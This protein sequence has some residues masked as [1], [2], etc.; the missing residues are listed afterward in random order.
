MPS[1]FLVAALT[2]ALGLTHSGLGLA[3]GDP[4]ARSGSKRAAAPASSEDILA[5]TVF[6]ALVG[7][8]ALQRGDPKLGSDA[9]ADLAVRTRD[10]KVIARATEIAGFARQYDRALELSK[11]WLEIE[12]DSAKARQTQ[13]SLLV[14]ANRLDDLAPQLAALLEQDKP[15]IGSNL[16]HLNRMLGKITD[17]KAVQ[18]L[19][20]KVAA[21]YDLL[22]EAHF[23]MAQAAANAGDNLRAL[24]ETEKSLQLRPAW[25]MAAIARAQLQ[26]RQSPKTAIDSLD[27]FV[28]RN[29]NANDARLT[30]ARLL[31]S[32]K[33]Y[34]ESR[35]HFDRLI[36]ANPD[37]P[38]VIYP[39]AM[40]AL[41]QGDTT[42]GRSQLE[43]L[44]QTDFPD[45]NTIH[46]FLGQLDQEQKKP[47]AA[48]AHYRQVAGGEQYVPARSR[49]AQ[50]LMQQGKL[51]EARSLLRDTRSGTPAERTQLAL[52]ESQLLREAGRHNDAYIVLDRALSAQPNDI[53]LLYEA[54]LTA[55]RIG[56][57]E[58]LEMHIKHLLTLK[59]DHAHALNALGYSLAERNLRLPEAYDLIAKALALAP[60]DPFIMDSM[61]W[62]LY[63]Q[64]KLNEALQT[65]ERAYR[66][67]ADPEIAA[68]LGEVLWTL[69]RKDEARRILRD[70]YKAYPENEALAGTVKKLLP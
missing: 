51:D 36:A 37:N 31:I 45:K 11:L 46:F 10:P 47:D 23:A 48:L 32:E 58:L 43:H 42:T 19:I 15:N 18:S 57:P 8:F 28:G 26:A 1:K 20:D 30:L 34:D 24:I 25:E 63:R 49:A 4:P 16:L 64:G 39:V 27:E 62:V 56:K 55:E 40:L 12:P 22:P 69:E 65:L 17:K 14:M 68:H 9:W 50:I 7:E 52:A 61:G 21:P 38:D 54:A 66:I 5:R 29:P 2:L 70:A 41:Q 33:R 53:E 67:K 3:A 60:E 13:S 59:P 35:H 44:L 6:Q